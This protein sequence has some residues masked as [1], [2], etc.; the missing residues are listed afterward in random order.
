M[1]LL[2]FAYNKTLN[3]KLWQGTSLKNSVRAKLKEIAEEFT[4]FIDVSGMKIDDVI[5][6]GSNANYNWTSSSDIDL[7][8]VVDLDQFAKICKDFTDDFFTDKKA[9]WNE[10]H[11]ANIYGH[12]VEV[13][14][15]DTKEKH[16]ASG[17]YS[18]KTNKWLTKPKHSKPDVDNDAV[19]T[20]VEQLK[21]EIDDVVKTKSSHQA[22]EKLW[23]KIKQLRKTG[24]S[25][26]GEH[27]V[28]NLTFKKLRSQGY[29]DKLSK[30][31]QN[32]KTEQ[33]SL[34]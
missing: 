18:L 11:K 4:Q 12:T 28:E 33:L 6:T 22:A 16:I 24:L 8:L 30:Y 19:D 32:A 2:E 10:R 7:H 14:V 26:N 29:L 27:S 20:K 17:V 23:D 34:R 21:D 25:K 9:L 15:Q 13:Y 3:P 5:L 31:K 1:K